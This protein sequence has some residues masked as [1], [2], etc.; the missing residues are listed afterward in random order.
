MT[1]LLG[2]LTACQYLDRTAVRLNADG[3]LDVAICE[4]LEAVASA[5]MQYN[6]RGSDAP[7]TTATPDTLPGRLEEGTVLDFG[8]VPS[9]DDWDRLFF[10]VTG[11]D[12]RTVSGVFDLRSMRHDEWTWA[13]QGMLMLF[14]DVEHCELRE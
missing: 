6:V 8:A 10:T 2:S 1:A 11:T 12:E 13:N 3:T 5:E 7:P 9:A 14:A 4:T